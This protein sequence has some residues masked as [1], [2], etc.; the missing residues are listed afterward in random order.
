MGKAGLLNFSIDYLI[1]PSGKNVRLTSD[2]K[3]KGAT[4][5]GAAVTE[6]L[7]LTPLFLL[8]KG[9]NTVFTK[10]QVFKVFVSKDTPI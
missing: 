2:I 6:A 10:G 1:A 9:K 4:K 5:T 3:S 8:K 7:L